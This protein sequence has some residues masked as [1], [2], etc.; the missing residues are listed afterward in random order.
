[1]ASVLLSLCCATDLIAPG[2]AARRQSSDAAICGV[3]LD[4]AYA[5]A[6]AHVTGR[7]EPLAA[8]DVVLERGCA[9]RAQVCCG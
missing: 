7:F 4:A 1:M 8:A 3:A 9:C 2:V 6:R 5:K